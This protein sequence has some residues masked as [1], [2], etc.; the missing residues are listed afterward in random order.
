MI[1]FLKNTISNRK[2]S[3]CNIYNLVLFCS[4]PPIKG[5]IEWQLIVLSV[6]I[7]YVISTPKSEPSNITNPASVPIMLGD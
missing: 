7:L 2:K 3:T 1:H 5:K 6:F 4:N